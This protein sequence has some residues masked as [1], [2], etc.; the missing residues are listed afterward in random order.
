MVPIIAMIFLFPVLIH[1]L[2]IKFEFHEINLRGYMKI[3]EL[4]LRSFLSTPN[5]SLPRDLRMRFTVGLWMVGC[6]FIV[7]HIQTSFITILTTPGVTS[8]IS[9]QK[10]LLESSLIKNSG[11]M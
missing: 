9:T 4:I 7:A 10:E 3:N 6:L 1:L 5:P 11:I 2:D 8:E